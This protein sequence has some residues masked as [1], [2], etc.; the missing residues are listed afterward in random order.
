M[1]YK[2]EVYKDDAGEWR[3]RMIA[4]NGKIIAVGEGYHNKQD[5]IG[6]IDS[7]KVNALSADVI[8]EGKVIG[9]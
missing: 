3:F 9:L 8:C 4:P 1:R 5:C 2:F 6:T 7:I